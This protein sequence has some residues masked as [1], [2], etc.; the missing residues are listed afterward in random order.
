MVIGLSDRI[1]MNTMNRAK[2]P[3]SY[4]GISATTPPNVLYSM[5]RPVDSVDRFGVNIGD[6]W[7]VK[8]P[9]ELWYLAS[10]E[11]DGSKPRTMAT[12]IRVYPRSGNVGTKQFVTNLGTANELDG[13][14]VVQGDDNITTYGATN[15]MVMS[16]NDTISLE[17]G[18]T[19]EG[20]VVFS[21]CTD[22]VVQGDGNGTLSASRGSDGQLLIGRTGDNPI[23]NNITSVDGSLLIVNGPNSITLSVVHTG[24]SGAEQFPTDNGIAN[25]NNRVLRFKG[26]GGTVTHGTGNAVAVSAT[27]SSVLEKDISVDGLITFDA[28]KNGTLQSDT[29]GVVS[30][31]RGDDGQLLI[32]RTSGFLQWKTIDALDDS[33][34]VTNSPGNIDL[35]ATN[36]SPVGSH[37]FLAVLGEPISKMSRDSFE[38]VIQYNC[39]V[40]KIDIG[41]N[42]EPTAGKFTAP[43]KGY[44][45]FN[46][47]LSA[48][49]M[50]SDSKQGASAWRNYQ[51]NYK[52]YLTVN[53]VAR[54]R[55]DSTLNKPANEYETF[56]TWHR[57][58]SYIP[59]LIINWRALDVVRGSIILLLEAGDVVKTEI[60][61]GV[62]TPTD[63]R[64]Q[65]QL[66]IANSPYALGV[67]RPNSV[68]YLTF[69]SGFMLKPV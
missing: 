9:Q 37:L 6:F 45:Y 62:I 8:R 15:T 10:L 53:D 54:Y 63:P 58:G 41:G 5:R 31:S 23:W 42:Y 4:L 55:V 65:S 36:I 46:V 61:Y 16:L 50:S 13:V 27:M 28:L 34:V 47:G 49:A 59:P 48:R 26:D 40:E 56:V 7:V 57:R 11:S 43:E 68:G 35:S 29:N 18:L 67:S 14:L 69:F 33:I 39:D 51:Y 22:G 30:T 21:S 2:S 12:W 44:Y 3:L 20:S 66:W 24:V 1:S 25:E 32:G 64:A 19:T 38:G 60:G 52:S 17:A